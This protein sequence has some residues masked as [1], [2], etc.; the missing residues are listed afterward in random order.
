[1]RAF[2]KLNVSSAFPATLVVAVFADL[3]LS[4]LHIHGITRPFFH[5]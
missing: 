2:W 3:M 1:V 4:F 5:W